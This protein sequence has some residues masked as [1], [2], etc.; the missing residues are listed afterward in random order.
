MGRVK[1]RKGE[2]SGVRPARVGEGDA[3]RNLLAEV[4]RDQ[5]DRTLLAASCYLLDSGVDTA[6]FAELFRLLVFERRRTLL[7]AVLVQGGNLGSKPGDHLAE[8]EAHQ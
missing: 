7:G 3:V 4:A 2:T 1:A 5:E 8:L 6:R